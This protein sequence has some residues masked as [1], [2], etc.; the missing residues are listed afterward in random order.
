MNDP[1]AARRK[2]YATFFLLLVLLVAT[3]LASRVDL[4]RLNVVVALAIACVKAALIAFTFMHLRHAHQVTRVWAVLGVLGL[5]LLIV[6]TYADTLTR[7][8]GPAM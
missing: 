6:L 4:G 3:V 7:G 5:G 2:Y 8:L 1:A